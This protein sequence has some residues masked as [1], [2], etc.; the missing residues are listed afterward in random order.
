[1]IIISAAIVSHPLTAKKMGVMILFDSIVLHSSTQFILDAMG[2][3]E[4][5]AG[6]SMT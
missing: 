4:K 6:C 3:E 1:M 5:L 2:R